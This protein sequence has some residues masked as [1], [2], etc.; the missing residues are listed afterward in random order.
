MAGLVAEAQTNPEFAELYR[1]HFVQPR[2]DATRE[3]LVRARDRGEIA[4]DTDLEVTLDLL[5]GPIYHRLLHGHAPLTERFAQ[6]VID[7]VITAISVS[8]TPLRKDHLMNTPHPLS[9]D[10]ASRLAV[11]AT[12][13]DLQDWALSVAVHGQVGLRD[14][15]DV[16]DVLRAHSIPQ[17]S[18]ASA[19]PALAAS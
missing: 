11:T 17:Y 16:L 15:V 8:P 4:A 14:L 5:Y 9:V 6:Q 13:D 7:H 18:D 3:L 19:F 12:A 2:R 1:E 10:E